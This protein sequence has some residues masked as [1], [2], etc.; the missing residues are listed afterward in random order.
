MKLQ[1]LSWRLLVACFAVVIFWSA[2]ES[3]SRGC[4]DIEATNFDVSSDKPCKDDCCKYP[5]LVC[6][7]SQKF[8][9]VLWKQDTA[10][11][12]DLGLHFRIKSVAFYLSGFELGQGG[13]FYQTTD[14][15]KMKVFGSGPADTVAQYFR[16]DYLLVR[17]VPV[18]YP[19][20]QFKKSGAFDTFRCN[21][22]LEPDANK[23][24]PRYAPSGH[25][26]NKQSDS[27]WLSRTEQY[28]WMQMVVAKD[29]F[30]TTIP[31]TLRFTAVD[32][33][34]LPYKI[35]SG[36]VLNHL[37]GFDFDFIFTVDYAK[38][39]SGVDFANSGVVA[40]KNQ[41]LLNLGSTFEV[42]Q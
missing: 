18:E 24:I 19:V 32:F 1:V 11:I 36:T 29:T 15:V 13:T 40:W 5:N 38:M 16:D 8:G 2:C 42:S 28:V 31:D 10:Y 20:G 14:S 35:T 39:F 37:T 6:S 23:I 33:G 17:R 21:L 27:L 12:N 25:P 34:G 3:P 41:I 9:G 26:L 7:V 30:L 22:G 4:L